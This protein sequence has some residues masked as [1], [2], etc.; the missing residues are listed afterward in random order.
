MRGQSDL[1]NASGAAA[2]LNGA[3]QVLPAPRNYAPVTTYR[4]VNAASVSGVFSSVSSNV[5]SLAPS[6]IYG[7]TTVAT[8]CSA[9][10]CSS[11]PMVPPPTRSPRAVP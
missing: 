7:A 5:A 6:L 9:M 2:I 1:I 3:V 10:T 4:I 8:N 11:V